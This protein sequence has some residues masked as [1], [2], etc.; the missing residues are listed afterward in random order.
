MGMINSLLLN[1]F[2]RWPIKANRGEPV[3]AILS[4]MN[5]ML[6]CWVWYV[7][8]LALLFYTLDKN[9]GW[10]L[11]CWFGGVRLVVNQSVVPVD[12]GV[13]ARRSESTFRCL[14]SEVIFLLLI[15]YVISS[16]LILPWF[17]AI[18]EIWLP[19]L[20]Y[21]VYL[22]LFLKPGATKWYQ[23]NA[24]CRTQA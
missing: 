17:V 5:P 3:S 24:D 18:C 6:C 10:V 23:S 19:G 4:L 22:V 13:F 20:T 14:F 2:E 16:L 15:R 8:T 1:C 7:L 9:S 11:D 21:S 12:F